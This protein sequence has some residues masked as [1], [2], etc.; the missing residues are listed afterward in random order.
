MEWKAMTEII[1]AVYDTSTTVTNVVD[2]LASTGIPREKIRVHESKPQVQVLLGDA[3][4]TE[5][6][7]ILQRHQPVELR[8][9]QSAE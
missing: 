4:E 7:E 1:T 8:T 9:D 3:I 6:K 5:I 2:D